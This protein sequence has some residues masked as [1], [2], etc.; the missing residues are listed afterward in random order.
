ML[1]SGMFV[2]NRSSFSRLVPPIPLAS[3]PARSFYPFLVPVKGG[4]RFARRALSR[5]R[6]L[7]S[8]MR[9]GFDS[10]LSVFDGSS[11]K[12]SKMSTYQMRGPKYPGINTSKMHD[13][14]AFRMNTCIKD[15]RGGPSCLCP[16]RGLGLSLCDR[17]P[18]QPI[19][20]SA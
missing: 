1:C 2:G 18:H 17:V 15:G 10:Q 6:E 12:C 9:S 7:N 5:S 19:L 13:L 8:L 11:A 14:N 20:Y 16:A 4:P 3:C